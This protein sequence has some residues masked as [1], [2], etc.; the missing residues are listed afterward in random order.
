MSQDEVSAVL[1]NSKRAMTCK[2][3]A[4]ATGL[5]RSSVHDITQRMNRRGFIER[6]PYHGV[7]YIKLRA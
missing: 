5:S 1:A 2:E 3:I 7:F 4:A 6:L